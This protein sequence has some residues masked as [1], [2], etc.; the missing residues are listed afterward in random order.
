[1]GTLRLSGGGLSV[2]VQGVHF[3]QETSSLRGPL[4]IVL[5]VSGLHTDSDQLENEVAPQFT[6]VAISKSSFFL[7][8]TRIGS[9]VSFRG[10]GS[11]FL[12][13]TADLMHK[14]NLCHSGRS[15]TSFHFPSQAKWVAS[16]QTKRMLSKC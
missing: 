6:P 13:K 9:V 3:R 5:P 8:L 2:P 7:S 12:L 15:F 4:I 11:H 14:R 16:E 10:K 1:M